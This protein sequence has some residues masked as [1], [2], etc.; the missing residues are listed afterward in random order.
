MIYV[1]NLVYYIDEFLS[2]KFDSAEALYKELTEEENLTVQ[3]LLDKG[4]ARV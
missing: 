4:F 1:V 3:S 2:R